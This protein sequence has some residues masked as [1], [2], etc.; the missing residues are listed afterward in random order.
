M[1]LF[2]SE[3]EI[4]QLGEPDEGFEEADVHDERPVRATLSGAEGAYGR[5]FRAGSK[6]EAGR[7][8]RAPAHEGTLR[9]KRFTADAGCLKTGVCWRNP[10]APGAQTSGE[11]NDRRPLCPQRSPRVSTFCEAQLEG[12]P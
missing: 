12:H 11:M 3:A 2:G 10:D 7:A 1:Q 5:G 4:L 6:K 8:A 9:A